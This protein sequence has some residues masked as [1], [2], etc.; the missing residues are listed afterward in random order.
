[1]VEAREARCGSNLT[2]FGVCRVCSRAANTVDGGGA[3]YNPTL[4]PA[5]PRGMRRLRCVV[6][7]GHGGLVGSRVEARHLSCVR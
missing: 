5:V 2:R 6:R 3:D 1:M 7:A 4:A